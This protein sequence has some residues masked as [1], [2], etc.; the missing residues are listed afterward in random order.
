MTHVWAV[1]LGVVQG[2]AEF[3][4]V[5]S[6]AH[7]KLTKAEAGGYAKPP[8]SVTAVPVAFRFDWHGSP[9]DGYATRDSVY[10]VVDA[11]TGR[12]TN[13]DAGFAGTPLVWPKITREQAV[14]IAKRELARH[15]TPEE[16]A[17]TR[18]ESCACSL[19]NPRQHPLWHV[20]YVR[21]MRGPSGEIGPDQM[22]GI[23]VDGLNG[24]IDQVSK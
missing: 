24:K 18:Q 8:G 4:P 15:R 21:T 17:Q 23:A 2:L 20:G 6:T 1:I 13:F 9:R 14:A 16:L 7:L 11:A 22:T 3:L 5:S 10:I 12:V 19:G